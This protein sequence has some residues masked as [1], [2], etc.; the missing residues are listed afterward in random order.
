MQPSPR[1]SPAAGA[2]LLSPR[3]LHALMRV[4]STAKTCACLCA[5]HWSNAHGMLRCSSPELTMVLVAAWMLL[6]TGRD[7]QPLRREWTDAARAAEPGARQEPHAVGAHALCLYVLKRDLCF[8]Y[9]VVSVDKVVD[10]LD[11]YVYVNSAQ[12]AAIGKGDEPGD[13][14][15]G[16]HPKGYVDFVAVRILYL[17]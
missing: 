1:A 17:D 14:A 7:A 3:H 5:H 6:A 8:V 10:L 13:V 2:S 9:V 16:E 4:V 15:L 12:C 11:L